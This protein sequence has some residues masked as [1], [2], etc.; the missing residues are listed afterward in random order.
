MITKEDLKKREQELEALKLKI[1]EQENVQNNQEIDITQQEFE[2]IEFPEE[3]RESSKEEEPRERERFNSEKRKRDDDEKPR[4][5]W[6]KP[7]YEERKY[8]RRQWNRKPITEEQRMDAWKAITLLHQTAAV[9]STTTLEL[10]ASKPKDEK[11]GKATE[12]VIS[13]YRGFCEI[14]S[15]SAD[16]WAAYT[17]DYEL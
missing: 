12:D 14:A 11:H 1:S 13:I 10:L 9:V 5:E 17:R 3:K 6:K 8:D 15:K 7:R 16:K 4:E 2:F